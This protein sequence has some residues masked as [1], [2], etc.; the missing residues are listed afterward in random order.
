MSRV[1]PGSGISRKRPKSFTDEQVRQIREERAE[2]ASTFELAA[3]YGVRAGVIRDA[4]SRRT[5]GWVE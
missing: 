3:K 1:V 2:G 4:V 5:Y